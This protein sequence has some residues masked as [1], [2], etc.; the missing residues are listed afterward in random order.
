MT[1]QIQANSSDFCGA[2]D[3]T[4]GFIVANQALCQ[5]SYISGLSM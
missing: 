1:L 2:G 4:H 3:K 5:L